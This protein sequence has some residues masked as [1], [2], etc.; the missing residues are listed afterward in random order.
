MTEPNFDCY[1]VIIDTDKYAGNF[2]REMCAYC[3]GRVGECGVGAKYVDEDEDYSIFKETVID[4]PCNHGCYRPVSIYSSLDN[5]GSN[6]SLC[7]FFES[8]PN[9]E[10]IEFISR[11]ANEYGNDNKIKINDIYV[12]K[13]EIKRTQ[14]RIKI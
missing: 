1:G 11:K 8:E 7:I 5:K 2:E 14:T 9:K 13:F 4:V 3:T 10:H 6:N 12:I